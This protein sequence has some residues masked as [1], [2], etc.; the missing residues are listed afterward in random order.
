[1]G[2]N[3]QIFMRC[4]CAFIII[5]IGSYVIVA[6]NTITGTWKTQDS[7]NWKN[8]DKN[9]TDDSGEERNFDWKDKDDPNKIYLNFR[10]ENSNGRNN[11]NGSS[12]AYE[13]LQGLTKA[14]VESANSTVSFRLTREAG[15]LECEGTFQSG[16]GS[17]T[18]RFTPNGNFVSAMQSRGF[19]NLS[20]EKL[21]ASVTLDITASFVDQVRTMGFKDLDY[22]DVFKAKIFKITP[23]YA[24]EMTSIGF[25]NLDMEDLVKA[26][27]FKIDADFARQVA[28]MGFKEKGLEDLV[29]FRI[30]KITPEY[31]REMQSAGFPNISSEEAVKLRIFKVTPE[32][33]REMQTEGLANLS[34][35]QATKLRIFNIDTNFIRQA[36]A[37]N[38]PINVEAL[39]QKRIG[40]WSKN[41]N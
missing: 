29:K 17:G 1:M 40:V 4:A 25:P 41:Q 9:K 35:E 15:T 27:I 11:A 31:L 28:A 7:S 22:D 8:K 36:R 14:Q 24:L 32:F 18:F 6:Q 13:D 37:E 3:I 16:K 5:I 19:S 34:V 38:V 21:F 20:T 26:R 2:K 10:Y 12:F 23:Q 39:V 33:V 30:F